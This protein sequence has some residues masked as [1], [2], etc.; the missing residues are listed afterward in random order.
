MRMQRGIEQACHLKLSAQLDQMETRTEAR[1]PK[2]KRNEESTERHT[3]NEQR[4]HYLTTCEREWRTDPQFQD[5]QHTCHEPSIGHT[6]N[7]EHTSHVTRY[8][9]E[10]FAQ[11]GEL[12][13]P[14]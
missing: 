1:Q 7:T 8:L 14:P 12:P 5:D 6:T 9:Y 3:Q 13:E 10:H 2:Q 4:A 11:L